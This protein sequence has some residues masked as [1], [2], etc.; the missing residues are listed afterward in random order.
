MIFARSDFVNVCSRC[1]FD[2]LRATTRPQPISPGRSSGAKITTNTPR[3]GGRADGR[4]RNLSQVPPRCCGRRT[5][6]SKRLSQPKRAQRLPPNKANRNRQARPTVDP[7]SGT[8]RGMSPSYDLA[9]TW[10]FFGTWR[11]TIVRPDLF[12]KYQV[13]KKTQARPQTENR[14]GRKGP[15]PH[16]QWSLQRAGG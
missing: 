12:Q 9:A 2:T 8:A 11:T 10:P 3:K 5:L 6:D 4:K 13:W 7:A 1:H 15:C 16:P 14:R